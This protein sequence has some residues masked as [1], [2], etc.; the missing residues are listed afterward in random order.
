M[1]LPG[2]LLCFVIIAEPVEDQLRMDR[3]CE[4]F[5]FVAKSPGLRN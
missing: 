1:I 4:D 2:S 5:E 3:L